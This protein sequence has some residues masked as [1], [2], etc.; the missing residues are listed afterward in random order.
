MAGFVFEPEKDILKTKSR[1]KKGQLS[2]S[3]SEGTLTVHGVKFQSK[4]SN[5]YSNQHNE[6]AFAIFMM[7]S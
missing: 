4:I 3:S 7:L 6:R 5:L 1:L 2:L